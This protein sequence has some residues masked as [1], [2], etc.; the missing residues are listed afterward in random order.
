MQF[1]CLPAIGEGWHPF[2]CC[3]FKLEIILYGTVSIPLVLRIENLR[4][5]ATTKVVLMGSCRGGPECAAQPE[6]SAEPQ[7]ASMWTVPDQVCHLPVHPLLSR[8]VHRAW[9][10]GPQALRRD[11]FSGMQCA[12][13]LSVTQLCL[14]LCNSMDCGTPGFPG[15]S[16]WVCTNPC[17]L[18]QWCHPAI[19]SSV[20]LYPSCPQSFP[21]SES[22]PVSQLF[23]LGDRSIGALSS[24]SVYPMN[25]QGWFPLGFKIEISLNWNLK[26]KNG[27]ILSLCKY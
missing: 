2:D 12:V 14:I 4:L 23:T 21:A 25:I 8:E 27:K 17:P 5:R 3:I 16:P 26:L 19:S 9:L 24:A 20:V 10:L 22:F 18:S 15:L 7:G 13:L 1:T 6:W 11:L